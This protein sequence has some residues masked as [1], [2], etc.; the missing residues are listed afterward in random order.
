MSCSVL[1]TVTLFFFI[2]HSFALPAANI[3]NFGREILRTDPVQPTKQ[4]IYSNRIVVE[5]QVAPEAGES[6]R[7]QDV[8]YVVTLGCACFLDANE[9]LDLP[10][11]RSSCSNFSLP[12]N[13]LKYFCDAFGA[14]TGYID[15]EQVEESF[16]TFQSLCVDESGNLKT[17]SRL[18]IHAGDDYHEGGLTGKPQGVRTAQRK[19]V[20]GFD[21]TENALT[22]RPIPFI[23][24][25]A[26]GV[27]K[28]AWKNRRK[29][30]KTVKKVYKAVKKEVKKAKEEFKE[31]V[32][33]KAEKKILVAPIPP[34]NTPT[35]SP[36]ESHLAR[37]VVKETNDFNAHAF[38]YRS[39]RTY[40]ENELRRT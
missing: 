19:G 37:E 17:F 3:G 25:V 24:R 12:I 32:K 33:D 39:Y 13:Q 21:L 36:V 4:E 16:D 22:E 40:A 31:S 15:L 7:C 2:S 9:D 14:E 11:I 34:G 1:F 20:N 8:V 5:R 35:P 38:R 27:A 28:L 18:A 26:W 29:I 30:E 6:E 23:A 10:V